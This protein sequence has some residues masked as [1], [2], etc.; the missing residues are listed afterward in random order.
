MQRRKFLKQTGLSTALITTV[1]LPPLIGRVSG[2]PSP[3]TLQPRSEEWIEKQCYAMYDLNKGFKT[4]VYTGYIIPRKETGWRLVQKFPLNLQ[5]VG[6]RRYPVFLSVAFDHTLTYAY[7]ERQ[8]K[9][10]ALRVDWLLNNTEDTIYMKVFLIELD[11]QAIG[12]AGVYG[13]KGYH[14]YTNWYGG[15]RHGDHAYVVKDV[16]GFDPVNLS[17][18]R[19]EIWHKKGA[20]GEVSERIC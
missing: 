17:T 3:F 16:P 18:A 8:T 4:N 14:R 20:Q 5:L 9:V 10:G 6:Q 7:T 11:G 15:V 12:R 19:L 1:G 2:S 13:H